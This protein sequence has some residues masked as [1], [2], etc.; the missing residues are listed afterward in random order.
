[1]KYLS[2]LMCILVVSGC[3]STNDV[4]VTKTEPV[5][6]RQCTANYSACV[7]T[8]SV[9]TPTVLFYQCK[10][11]LKLCLQTCPPK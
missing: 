9:G 2:G 6:A 10:E 3:V 11:A 4:D 1:M 8:P 7:S 5:C